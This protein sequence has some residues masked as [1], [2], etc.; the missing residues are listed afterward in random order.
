MASLKGL[1]HVNNNLRGV[2]KQGY[3]RPTIADFFSSK[4]DYVP[5][6]CSA[7]PVMDNEGNIVYSNSDEIVVA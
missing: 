5:T 1:Y 6:W 7:E 4:S 2:A 3:C